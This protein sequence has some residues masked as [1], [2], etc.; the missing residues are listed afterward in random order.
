MDM[1]HGMDC[2]IPRVLHEAHGIADLSPSLSTGSSPSSEAATGSQFMA[3]AT[4]MRSSNLQSN[5][6]SLVLRHCR[7]LWTASLSIRMGSCS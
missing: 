6:A 4:W 5:G 2:Q 3:T 1:T 7:P